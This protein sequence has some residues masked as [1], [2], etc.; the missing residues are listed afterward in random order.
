YPPFYDQDQFVTYK[1]ILSG[2]IEFPR[3]FDYAAKQLLRKLLNVDQQ[4]R[5]GSARD[6]GDEIKREQWFVGVNWSDV[7]ELKYEPPIQPVVTSP[8]DTANFDS[9]DE[10]DLKMVPVAAKYE[11]QLFKDF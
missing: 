6:G 9:Y 11:I 10:T 2:K 8:G 5:L 4:S 7:T 1:K 3:H